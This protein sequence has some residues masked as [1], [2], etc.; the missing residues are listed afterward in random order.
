MK[1]KVIKSLYAFVLSVS[2]ATAGI[3][4]TM[5]TIQV[6]AAEM[7]VRTTLTTPGGRADFGRGDASI[8][9]QGNEGQRLTGKSFH[10]YQLFYAENAAGGESINYTFHPVYE[11]SLKTVVGKKLG[12]AAESVTEYEVIDYIQS[13][14][15]NQVEG[16][17]AEQTLEGS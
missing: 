9:I 1:N 2:V 17:Q 6:S 14:N 10:V 15:R 4:G 8:T 3:A 13:L 12:K 11:N 7:Q 5:G 16:A